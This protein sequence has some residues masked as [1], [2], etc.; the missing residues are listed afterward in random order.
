LIP[1]GR[2]QEGKPKMANRNRNL[3]NFK[4]KAKRRRHDV[5]R[6]VEQCATANR[7]A[8][9]RGEQPTDYAKQIKLFR[10]TRH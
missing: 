4:M 2:D 6:F 3:H 1:A 8:V 7:E 9:G 5:L 10:E